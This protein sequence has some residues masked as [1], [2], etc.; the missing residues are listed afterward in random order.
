MFCKPFSVQ[1]GAGDT[2][3]WREYL[4]IGF[5]P[6]KSHELD[7]RS[8][9][10][11][12]K[13]SGELSPQLT[14]F[15]VLFGLLII[16]GIKMHRDLFLCLARIKT[17][18]AT[19]DSSLLVPTTI[20]GFLNPFPIPM[21][22]HIFN[23]YLYLDEK[24]ADCFFPQ[25]VDIPKGHRIAPCLK[26]AWQLGEVWCLFAMFLLVGVCII[27][28][29]FLAPH[30]SPFYKQDMPWDIGYGTCAS[31]QCAFDELPWISDT[32]YSVTIGW[33][34]IILSLSFTFRTLE[35]F[36]FHS[37]VA[38]ITRTLYFARHE[39]LDVAILSKPVDP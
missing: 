39:L 36:R 31:R 25:A 19:N 23:I 18:A 24:A 27:A 30:W 6:D 5:K 4:Y 38:I 14:A 9:R 15:Y 26:I 33:G 8:D 10:V 34:L 12:L 3:C 35:S 11:Q 37:G 13:S 17:F 1:Q 21:V 16:Y 28:L 32:A 29:P 22:S 7:I 2:N 20:W